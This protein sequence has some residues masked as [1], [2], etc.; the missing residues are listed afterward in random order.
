MFC[1]TAWAAHPFT[2]RA[3]YEQIYG[4]LTTPRRRRDSLG[5]MHDTRCSTYLP[6][7]A[8]A[9]QLGSAV[10]QNQSVY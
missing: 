8:H 9:S 1:A 3:V 4:R 10:G 6:P 7:V 5:N 2:R